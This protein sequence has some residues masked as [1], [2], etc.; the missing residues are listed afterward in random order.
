MKWT[1]PEICLVI[2]T[3]TIPVSIIGLI[4]IRLNGNVIGA[5]AGVVIMDMLKYIS[6]G[7]IGVIAALVGKK[8][9]N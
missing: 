2:L 5:E 7:V 3:L 6:G 8:F 1:A 4:V 9:E